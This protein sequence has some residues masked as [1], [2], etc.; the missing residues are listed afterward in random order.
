MPSRPRA[1]MNRPVWAPPLRIAE[2]TADRSSRRSRSS[3]SVGELEVMRVGAMRACHRAWSA[4]RLP[5]PEITRWLSSRALT[6]ERPAPT[7]ARNSAAADVRGVG[8]YVGE[9]RVEHRAPQA[10]P[11]AQGKA[12]A[13]LELD[14]E[15]VPARV[16]ARLVQRDRSGHPEMQAQSTGPSSVSSHRNFPRRCALTNRWPTSAAAISPGGCGRHTY[17]SRSSTAM[18]RRP[19]TVS[20]RW[21]AR[22]ASGSSGMA[23]ERVERRASAVSRADGHKTATFARVLLLPTR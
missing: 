16:R 10:A 14:R 5:T 20:S 11:V 4:S 21:R 23:P 19:S 7:R 2:R 13:I 17:V 15:P 6:G 1:A 18:I 3:S 22:S 9:V 12:A 8:A